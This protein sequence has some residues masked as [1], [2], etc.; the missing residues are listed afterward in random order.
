MRRAFL[1]LVLLLSACDGLVAP[2]DGALQAR[3]KKTY[4]ARDACLRHQVAAGGVALA[5]G[6]I[7]QAAAA[8]CQGETDRLIAAQ[9]T[10]GDA[11]VT[12]SIRQD[13]EFRAMKYALQA[14]GLTGFQEQ[15]AGGVLNGR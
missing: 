10:D 9:N 5:P 3:M 6:T 13:T 4:E 12:A 2:E 8:A 1:F 15:A 14:R 7:A 11:T